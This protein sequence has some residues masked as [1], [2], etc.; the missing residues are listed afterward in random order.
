MRRHLVTLMLKTSIFML[1]YWAPPRR[2]LAKAAT[3]EQVDC[4]ELNSTFSAKNNNT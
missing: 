4:A 3:M 2:S 1:R